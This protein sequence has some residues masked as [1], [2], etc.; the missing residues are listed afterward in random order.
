[1]TDFPNQYEQVRRAQAGRQAPATAF[2]R[3]PVASATAAATSLNAAVAHATVAV[4]V[5]E[6][7]VCRTGVPHGQSSMG[8]EDYR[9]KA[10]EQLTDRRWWA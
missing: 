5:S 2:T 4:W 10:R 1:M 3:T 6:V 7:G 8:C 9:R